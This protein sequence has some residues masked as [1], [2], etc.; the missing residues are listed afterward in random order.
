M[1]RIGISTL[2]STFTPFVTTLFACQCFS[3]TTFTSL[4]SIFTSR[5]P[6]QFFSAFFRSSSFTPAVSFMYTTFGRRSSVSFDVS[7]RWRGV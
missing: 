5:T 4:P 2:S 7:A 3:K 6:T 1:L